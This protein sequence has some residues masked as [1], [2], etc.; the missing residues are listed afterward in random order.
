MC[1]RDSP[2]ASIRPFLLTEEEAA[3][4]PAAF[5]MLAAKGKGVEGHQFRIQ[6]SP[7]DCQGCGSCV[8]VCPAKNKALEMAEVEAQPEEVA[9]WEY[10]VTLSSKDE[11]VA[12]SNVKNS[13]FKQPLLEFSG[14]C[15]G[16]GET[17]YAK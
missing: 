9:N 14:A 10:A 11:L 3:K 6:V 13:Q 4:A 7:L 2:H 12:P 5:T 1:I 15:A 17:P 16:C 8:V